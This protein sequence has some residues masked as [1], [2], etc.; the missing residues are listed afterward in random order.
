MPSFFKTAAI[1]L[2]FDLGTRKKLEI[3][4]AMGPKTVRCQQCVTINCTFLLHC[5]TEFVKKNCSRKGCS[6]MAKNAKRR[7]VGWIFRA[8][9]TRKDGTRDWARDHGYKAWCI[10]VYAD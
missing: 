10:P 4:S 9:V 2:Y 8:W 1:Q 5:P 7:I 3:F 6:L